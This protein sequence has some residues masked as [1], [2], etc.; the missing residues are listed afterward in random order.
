MNNLLRIFK[1]KTNL[2]G[3]DFLDFLRDLLVLLILLIVNTTCT[4]LNLRMRNQILIHA[5][6]DFDDQTEAICKKASFESIDIKILVTSDF[7]SIPLFAQKDNIEI[8]KKNSLRGLYL[9]KTSKWIFFTHGLH[10]T[11]LKRK[12]QITINLWHG[13][14]FKKVGYEI[15]I[16]LPLADFLVTSSKST[17]SIFSRMYSLKRRPQNLPFGLPRNDQFSNKSIYSEKFPL[18]KI[19][20]LPTYRKSSFG[21]M[22]EDGD[23]QETNLGMSISQLRRLDAECFKLGLRIVL[24]AHPASRV[25]LPPDLRSI[26][27]DFNFQSNF[28]SQFHE[29]DGLITDY[30]SVAADF[31][32]T[33]KP[34]FLFALDSDIYKKDRGFFKTPQEALGLPMNASI[35]QLVQNI[36]TPKLSLVSETVLR[37]IHDNYQGSAVESIWKFFSIKRED[38][39]KEDGVPKPNIKPQIIKSKV[40]QIISYGISAGTSTIPLIFS[41]LYLTKI[42]SAKVFLYISIYTL[43][44]GLSRVIFG[45]YFLVMSGKIRKFKLFAAMILFSSIIVIG[46]L[47]SLARLEF[48][49]PLILTIGLLVFSGFGILQDVLRYAAFSQKSYGKIILS[50]S[51][52]LFTILVI[53]IYLSVSNTNVRAIHILLGFST[54]ALIGCFSLKVLFADLPSKISNGFEKVNNGRQFVFLAGISLIGPAANYIINLYLSL[55][56]QASL[57]AD[58]R[59]LQIF[60]LPIGFLIGMQQIAWLPGLKDRAKNRQ[61]DFFSVTVLAI[62][63]PTIILTINMTDFKFRFSNYFV[64]MVILEAVLA[65]VIAQIGYQARAEL[66][67]SYYFAGRLCW[68][69]LVLFSVFFTASSGSPEILATGLV[70]SS[71]ISLVVTKVLTRK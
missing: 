23:S 39:K 41:F 8:V 11:R 24:K 46:L 50:D 33:G 69:F 31:A 38:E 26:T 57:L 70:A 55:A 2:R 68:F 63:I 10:W 35:D 53:Y 6:P 45:D 51:L 48:D 71:L 59:S 40:V 56:S 60:L 49:S 58:L 52:W 21:E 18:K 67:Y 30:S 14:P 66:K 20:W 16:R 43:I 4:I 29:F 1:Q 64:L 28:Y 36:G 3:S 44:Q 42:E 5:F 65:F 27:T 15:G 22:R 19:L 25:E 13:I 61:V 32:L 37:M 34:I 7:K 9:T 17:S 47:T 54:G 12:S 62:V